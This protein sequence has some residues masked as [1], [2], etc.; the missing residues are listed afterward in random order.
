[1]AR[2]YILSEDDFDDQ[3]YVYVLET[4]L[5]ARVDPIPLR[6]RRGGGV[7]EVRKKL[8]LLLAA[9]R[10]A[11][12]IDDTYF[13]VS[14]D[15][16]RVPEHEQHAPR[17]HGCRHCELDDA[18]RLA[19]PDG[20][21]IPGAVAVPV[22]MIEAWL[23]LMYDPA[24]YV[25]EATLPQCG[26]RDQAVA[27]GIYGAEPP[28]QLKDLVEMDQRASGSSTKSDFAL[29]CVLRLDP[30]GLAVRSPSFAH[31]RRQVSSWLPRSADGSG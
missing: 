8:P 7:G 14:L 24:R 10:R 25:R 28:P 20:W 19:M 6:L 12:P 18:I 26:R 13:V 21:P 5:G 2:V 9:I 27:R 1:M 30:D 31:F 3:V 16:D 23:L 11:G 22:Q 15:N 29:A 17:A 4:L